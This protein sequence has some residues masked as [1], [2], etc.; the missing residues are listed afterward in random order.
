MGRTL[1]TTNQLI[2]TEMSHFNNFRRALRVD[3]QK[4]FDT[5]FAHALQHT[6]AISLADHALPFESVLLAILIEQ[7]RQIEQLESNLNN[8]TQ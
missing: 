8:L 7:Q 1:Q 3:D 2:H 6:A 4:L 5:L